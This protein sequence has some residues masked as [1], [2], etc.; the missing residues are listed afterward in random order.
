MRRVLTVSSRAT[1]VA[2]RKESVDRNAAMGLILRNA[3]PVALRKESVDRNFSVCFNVI[4]H[5][6]ALRKESVDRNIIKSISHLGHFSRSPQG[7]RG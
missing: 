4:V 6:V 3:L 2:L 7:E 1:A 5:S